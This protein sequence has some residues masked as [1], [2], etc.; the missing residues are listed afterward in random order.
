VA[1]DV[2]FTDEFGMW[3]ATLTEEQQDDL[4]ARVDL[5]AEAGPS[6]RRPVVGEIVGS[7][8]DPQMKELICN[9]GGAALRVL[10][11]FDP[12]RT[13]ILLLGGDKS[14]QWRAWYRQAIPTADSLY[15]TYLDELHHEGLL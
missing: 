15:R 13:A 11:V 4:R 2:E 14:G 9:S 7:T 5:L 8:F 10:F 1:Y 12:N 3:W 6:L